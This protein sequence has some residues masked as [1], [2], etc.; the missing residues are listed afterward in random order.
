MKD[1]ITIIKA[2]HRKLE[3]LFK[4]YEDLGEKAYKKKEDVS[5]EIITTLTIHA[6]MEEKIL[7]P[8]LKPRF[9]KE[10]DFLVNEAYVEHGIAKE[11]LSAIESMNPEHEYYDAKVK[12][13]GEIVAHH[14]KEEENELLPLVKKE[15]NEEEL[16]E[17]GIQMKEFKGENEELP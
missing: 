15:F 5:R 8:K 17:M 2:D 4:D 14:V 6:E 7:Y 9:K 3:K 16:Q 11:L 13:L 12:V 1:A 10:N